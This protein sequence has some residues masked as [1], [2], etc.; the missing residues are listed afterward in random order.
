M[1]FCIFCSLAPSSGNLL[2]ELAPCSTA[3]GALAERRGAGEGVARMPPNGSAGGGG[4]GAAAAAA[5]VGS[6][7]EEARF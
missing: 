3:A 1:G 6:A 7:D 5:H 2:R 4:G